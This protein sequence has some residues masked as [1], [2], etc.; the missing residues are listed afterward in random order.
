MEENESKGRYV[1]GT[2]GER[3]YHWKTLATP[4]LGDTDI[5]EESR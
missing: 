2:K 4:T 5:D 3:K 1:R